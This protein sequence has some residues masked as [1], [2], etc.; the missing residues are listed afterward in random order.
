MIWKRI[1]K[2]NEDEIIERMAESTNP[3]DKNFG[4]I[5]F[6]TEHYNYDNKK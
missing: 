6:I 5:L 2:L 1:V 3:E 4:G